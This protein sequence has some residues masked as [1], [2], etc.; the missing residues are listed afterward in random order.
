MQSIGRCAG[1]T[2]RFEVVSRSEPADLTIHAVVKRQPTL[3][4]TADGN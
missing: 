4:S 2:E 1:L 3:P